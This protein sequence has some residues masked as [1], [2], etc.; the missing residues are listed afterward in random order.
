MSRFAR[1]ETTG[2]VL[3]AAFQGWGREDYIYDKG[4]GQGCG[5]NAESTAVRGKKLLMTFTI[6]S[7]VNTMGAYGWPYD[8]IRC[9]PTVGRG[10]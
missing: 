5:N 8:K 3:G 4:L 9:N 1:K 6:M 7:I 10:R 2:S